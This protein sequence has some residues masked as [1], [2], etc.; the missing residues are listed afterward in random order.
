MLD[1]HSE[2]TQYP[3]NLHLY[4]AGREKLHFVQGG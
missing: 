4:L 2:D 1:F 3:K